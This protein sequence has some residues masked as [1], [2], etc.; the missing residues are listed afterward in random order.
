MSSI[1][2][3]RNKD[4]SVINDSVNH[5]S[6]GV[7]Y[8]S[9]KK[10]YFV[11]GQ[12]MR[13]NINQAKKIIEKNPDYLLVAE[14]KY[15]S[16]FVEVFE[17]SNVHEQYKLKYTN[18]FEIYK[19]AFKSLK[20]RSKNERDRVIEIGKSIE[21]ES[22][23]QLSFELVS[24]NFVIIEEKIKELQKNKFNP[25]KIKNVM[26]GIGRIVN[27]LTSCYYFELGYIKSLSEIDLS[28]LDDF[29]FELNEFNQ[30]IQKSNCFIDFFQDFMG[31]YETPIYA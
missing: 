10:K 15:L 31:D 13:F 8:I 11:Y 30:K 7:Q 27:Y 4:L 6:S 3:N 19:K 26:M 5:V 24:S 14:L 1:D 18:F 21:I 9:K 16:Y 28:E 23:I 2:K 29:I 20:I 22:K 12:N 25:K 17:S